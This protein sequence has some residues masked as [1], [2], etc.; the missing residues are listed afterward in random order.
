LTYLE[1][2]GSSYTGPNDPRFEAF[3]KN[4]TFTLFPPKNP[5]NPN[6]REQRSN[7]MFFRHRH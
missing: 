4:V 2:G 3:I 6:F 7:H 5:T 1:A